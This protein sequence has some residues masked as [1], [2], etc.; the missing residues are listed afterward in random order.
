[1]SFLSLVTIC[2]KVCFVWNKYCYPGFLSFFL[3]EVYLIY[4]V[5]PISAVQQSDSVTDIY[6][7]FL[8]YSFPL[9]FTQE[10]GYSSLCYTVGPCCL[11]ILNV[12]VCIYQ[13]P[14]P[15]KI[16]IASWICVSSLHRSHANLLCIVLILV[17]VLPKGTLPWLSFNFHFH[18]IHFPIPLLSVSVC[19]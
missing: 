2:F 15:R 18:G 10:I 6:T 3:I 17:Y 4:N 8:K 1:M 19:L 16:W 5:M 9:W 13:P 12:I 7:F 14:I 11:S